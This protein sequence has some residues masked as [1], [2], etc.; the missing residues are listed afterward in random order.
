MI[1][2][3]TSSPSGNVYCPPAIKNRVS[4]LLRYFKTYH[5]IKILSEHKLMWLTCYSNDQSVCS[6]LSNAGT[7]S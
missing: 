2:H 7:A 1:P 5:R 6:S 3:I 4:E